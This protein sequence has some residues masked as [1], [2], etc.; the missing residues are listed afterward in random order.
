MKPASFEYLAPT[1]LDE[2]LELLEK[3]GDEAK[4]LAGGQSLVATMNFR[5]AQPALLV[6]I[7][8]VPALSYIRESDERVEIG[9]LTRQREVERSEIVARRC[10][11]LHQTMPFIAHPQI[12]N[13]GTFGGSL[14]H[15][16]PASELPA[17]ALVLETQMVISRQGSERTVAAED[18]FTGLFETVLEPHEML[19]EVRIPD[20]PERT[21]TAFVEMSR[22]SGDFALVGV[23]VLV[24]LDASGTIERCRIGLHSVADRAILARK[25]MSSLIGEKPDRVTIERAAEVA[26]REDIDPTGDLHASADYRRHLTRVLVRRALEQASRPG[27]EENPVPL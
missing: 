15:A 26:A 27:S 25:A 1:S 5:L 12:R 23:A 18:F 2:V 17:V 14:A 13:R 21:G 8:N 10:P 16:D 22:R 20:Q 24:R 4:I 6:D 19:T 9:A 7:N 11:L 3:H